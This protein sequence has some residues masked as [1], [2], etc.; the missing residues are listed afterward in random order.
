MIWARCAIYCI[1]SS[2]GMHVGYPRLFLRARID[3]KAKVHSRL[4]EFNPGIRLNGA[5]QNRVAGL[6]VLHS[7]VA[8]IPDHH[9]TGYD[10]IQLFQMSD[11]LEVDHAGIAPPAKFE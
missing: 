4:K 3:T 2:A 10:L 8:R 5:D 1:L 9:P 7:Q 6:K 11:K